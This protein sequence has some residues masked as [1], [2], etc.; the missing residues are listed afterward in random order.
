MTDIV[1]PPTIDALPPAPQPADTPS[2]FDSKA[3]AL[4]AAQVAM[5]GDFNSA[6]AATQQ[7][8][9][10]ANERAVAAA[11]SAGTAAAAE[12][13]ATAAAGTASTAAATATTK[14]GEASASAIAASKLNLGPKA[15]APV[16]DN[17]GA[18]LL[19]GATYYDTTLGKWRVWNGAAWTDGIS[20]VAG[21]A[22][23]NGES[24]NLV[25]TTLA[26]YGITDGVT[27]AGVQTLE[28]KT[29]KG[30]TEAGPAEANAGA[31][32]TVD[33]ANGSII[34]LVLNANCTFT[35]P[36]PGFGKQFTLFLK[37][38]GAFTYALPASAR[39]DDG[40]TLPV[41]ASGKTATLSFICDGTYWLC[42]VG[43]KG[44]T[45]A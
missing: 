4:L 11:A 40:V 29:I 20:A 14:A 13:T 31:A 2:E 38:S 21:V 25:K 18:A 1:T 41:V 19:A 35:F 15:V 37:Q 26:G 16:V 9:T 10:A 36:A 45:R 17:Q 32:Y 43:A 42:Y 30:V 34:P 22:S 24:G 7:N 6:A 33:L 44:H 27:P 8:A 5:V 23:L 12:S 28:N 3:F 39:V